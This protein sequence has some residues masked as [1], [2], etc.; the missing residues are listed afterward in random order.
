MK[1]AATRV[2]HHHVI[3]QK[4]TG[5]VI[6]VEHHVIPQAFT[7]PASSSITSSTTLLPSALFP[8]TSKKCDNCNSW[9]D[10]SVK[11]KNFK[12]NHQV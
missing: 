10:D 5:L 12:T 2:Q 4:I 9:Y 6:P 11:E 7:G 1:P 3:Q 8:P